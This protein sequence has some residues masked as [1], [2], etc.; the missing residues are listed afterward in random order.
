MPVN[1]SPLWHWQSRRK[2]SVI[3]EETIC[4]HYNDI[5]KNANVPQDHISKQHYPTKEYDD[6]NKKNAFNKFS[7]NLNAVHDRNI[8]HLSRTKNIDPLRP[9]LLEIPSPDVIQKRLLQLSAA[10]SRTK[11]STLFDFSYLNNER[12][13]QKQ[14]IYKKVDGFDGN[15]TRLFLT[16]N[17][18]SVTIAPRLSPYQFRNK[19][20][21]TTFNILNSSRRK[22][23]FEI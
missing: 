8:C 11:L 2:M 14:Q 23:F 6:S 13:Q 22:G 4:R 1:L 17:S 3:R 16:C 12:Q 19:F 18:P 7:S 15:T 10:F 21:S 20:Q 5:E 9:P